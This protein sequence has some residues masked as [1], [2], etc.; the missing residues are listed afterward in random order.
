MIVRIVSEQT[1]SRKGY[2]HKAR[3]R[4]QKGMG[5]EGEKAARLSSPIRR[6]FKNR[7]KRIPQDSINELI[8]WKMNPL[9]V[10]V[11][12]VK[13]KSAFLHA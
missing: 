4:A 10:P 8:I 7:F 11:T 3:K 6:N 5:E 9:V 2:G 1:L 12:K 13:L